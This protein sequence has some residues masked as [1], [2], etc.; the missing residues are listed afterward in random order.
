M[1]VG[2]DAFGGSTTPL[3]GMLAHLHRDLGW[4]LPEAVAA[5]STRPAQVLNLAHRKGRLTAGH[6]ADLAVLTSDLT[7]QAT[8]RAGHWIHH[9]PAR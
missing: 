1:V 7:V 9:A 6:D 5:T 4:P 2:A 8:M 3:D